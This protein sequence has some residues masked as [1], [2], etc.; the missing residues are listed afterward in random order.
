MNRERL[1]AEPTETDRHTDIQTDRQTGI[2]LKV[3][4]FITLF[5][6]CTTKMWRDLDQCTD[7]TLILY[8]EIDYFF[9]NFLAKLDKHEFY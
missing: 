7:K 8:I 5:E 4:S 6:T 2:L 3:F 9:S 1:F